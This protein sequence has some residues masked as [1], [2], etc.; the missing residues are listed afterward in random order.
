[1]GDV[2]PPEEPAA[3]GGSPPEDDVLP[4]RFGL[5]DDVW[6]TIAAVMIGV[7]TLTGAWL[8]Y[9]SVQISDA[10][11]RADARST[12]EVVAIEQERTDAAVRVSAEMAAVAQYRVMLAEADVIDELPVAGLDTDARDDEARLRRALAE[13]FRIVS[14]DPTVLK[15]EGADATYDVDGRSDALLRR[16]QTVAQ[17]DPEATSAAAQ[18]DHSRSVRL[19]GWVGALLAVVGLLSLAELVESRTRPPLVLIS[20]A[21]FV[22]VV[23]LAVG[24]VRGGA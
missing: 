8:T 1:M 16:N 15:G 3:A 21:G 14:F 2:T 17:M 12:A 11:G 19:V 6:K 23:V 9:V 10:A 24:T 5:A 7:A 13:N 18:R 22:V 4:R 20:L